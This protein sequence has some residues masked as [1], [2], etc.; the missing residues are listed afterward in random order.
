MERLNLEKILI[1]RKWLRLRR[2]PP[3]F[4][5]WKYLPSGFNRNK[6][7]KWNMYIAQNLAQPQLIH[8]KIILLGMGFGH[9][10]KSI[11]FSLQMHPEHAKHTSGSILAFIVD[12]GIC[13]IVEPYVIPNI[14]LQPY[15]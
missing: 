6:S 1:A 12:A 7:L 13:N 10:L 15:A 4:R 8:A 3:I 5:F 9:S 11:R 2:P 14:M